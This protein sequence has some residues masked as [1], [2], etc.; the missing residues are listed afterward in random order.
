MSKIGPR[1]RILLS[2]SLVMSALAMSVASGRLRAQ[3]SSPPT[4]NVTRLTTLNQNVW[5]GDFNGDGITDL[6]ASD[7]DTDSF[8]N[9][10]I[11]ILLGNGNG[12]FSPALVRTEFHGKVLGV[13]DFNGDGRLD[14]VAAQRTDWTVW[15][16]EV[17]PGFGDGSLD[18]PW[19]V[20]RFEDLT[21]ARA[22]DFDRDGNVD[23]FVF[24]DTGMSFVYR[25]NGNFQWDAPIAYGTEPLPLDGTT[26]DLNGDGKPD[27]IVANHYAW[28]L[29]IF[30]NTSTPGFISFTALDFSQERAPTGKGIAMQYRPST[31]A[32]S[33]QVAQI[34][35]VAP[36]F[37]RLIRS[38]NTFV[39][40]WSTDWST[41]HTA[42]SVTVAVDAS[43]LAGIAL[44]SHDTSAVATAKFVDPIVG[45]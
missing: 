19:G 21:F 34:A 36:M 42:G 35:G 33:V 44:T 20:D 5:P 11:K 14:V 29:N 9:A 6:V 24:T 13:G 40:A 27:V 45:R 43:A 16:V 10:T 7:T 17:L 41:W 18:E 1:P 39:G 32:A 8:G 4:V 26:A 30:A 15:F 31:G 3:S 23:L 28:T 25:G 37:L 38:G 12:T 2:L 22:A